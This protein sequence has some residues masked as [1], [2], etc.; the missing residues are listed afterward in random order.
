MSRQKIF[1]SHHVGGNQAR[2]Q[3][4]IQ[5]K[6]ELNAVREMSDAALVAELSRYDEDAV[7]QAYEMLAEIEGEVVRYG[8]SGPGT[9]KT[10]QL[11]RDEIARYEALTREQLRRY[12]LPQP[13]V[14]VNDCFF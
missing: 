14:P 11:C 12:P 1:L 8:D 9:A 2:D 7:Q 6:I 13:E 3:N 10:A 5:M 4:E